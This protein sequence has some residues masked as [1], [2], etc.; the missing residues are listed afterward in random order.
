MTNFIN[1]IRYEIYIW[2]INKREQWKEFKAHVKSTLATIRPS[3]NNYYLREQ[4]YQCEADGC[5]KLFNNDA[6]HAICPYCGS[7]QFTIIE[8]HYKDFFKKNPQFDKRIKI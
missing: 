6:T 7:R 3:E 5:Y 1:S 4:L 8:A 2:F